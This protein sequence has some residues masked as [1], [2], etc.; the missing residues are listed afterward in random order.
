VAVEQTLAVV[1]V[2]LELQ[3]KAWLL[4]L[5]LLLPLVVAAQLAHSILQLLLVAIV[6]LQAQV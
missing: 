5:Q 6:Q 2:D 4:H 3:L 1:L